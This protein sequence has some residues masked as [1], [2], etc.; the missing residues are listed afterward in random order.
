MIARE[1]SPM[2]SV[3]APELSPMKSVQSS[4]FLTYIASVEGLLLTTA[5][6]H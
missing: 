2:K 3:I 5:L 6:Y 1:L 4:S